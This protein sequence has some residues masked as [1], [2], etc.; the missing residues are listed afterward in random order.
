MP[1]SSSYCPLPHIPE[2]ISG[3]SLIDFVEAPSLS[4][5]LPFG[6]RDFPR[7]GSK[8]TVTVVNDDINVHFILMLVTR[9][10][11]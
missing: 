3:G 6:E 9:C 4:S 10:P 5:S 2:V 11:A 8:D 7:K 1:S